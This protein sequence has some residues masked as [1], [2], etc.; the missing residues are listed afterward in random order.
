MSR[1]IV[2]VSGAPGAGK[3]TVSVP[4]A[5]DLGFPLITRDDMK[6]TLGDALDLPSMDLAQSQLLGRAAMAVLWTVAARCPSAVLDAPFRPRS[7]V[8]RE[9]LE[10]LDA[11][12]VEVHCSCSPA[13]AIERYN[14]R[15]PHRHPVHVLQ[16]MTPEY[17]VQF[18]GTL[19]VGPVIEVNTEEAVD[20]ARLSCRVR[21]L[22]A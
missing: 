15:A 17:L 19:G 11:R 14:A 21:E 22:L 2:L 4:L 1:R 20:I 8:E 10:S 13:L 16:V 3:T 5:R 6:E 18:E 12:F 9:R 7:P